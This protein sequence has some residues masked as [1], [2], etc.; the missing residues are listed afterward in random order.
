MSGHPSNEEPV[1]LFT[2]G[3]SNHDLAHFLGLLASHGIRVL[4]DARTSPFVQYSTHFNAEALRRA[5]EASAVRYVFR[6]DEL[7]GRPADPACYDDR[8]RVRY[9]VAAR[10]AGFIRALD[11]VIAIARTERVALM[12]SEEDPADCHRRL[13]IGRVAR[14]RGHAIV[15]IRGD[16]SAQT[17]E[18]LEARLRSDD[19]RRNQLDLFATGEA[20]WKSTR[21]VL[22]KQRRGTSSSDSDGPEYD[23]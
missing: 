18:A 2:I 23:D 19:P 12:C 10:K 7:G 6:G 14:E 21:S 11:E 8:G 17:E 13:L 16:G 3:H 5:V 20:E 4:V 1:V 9:D 15:H 22:Q